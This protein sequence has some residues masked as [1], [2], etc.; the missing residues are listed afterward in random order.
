MGGAGDMGA[1][2]DA[3][4]PQPAGNPQIREKR[5]RGGINFAS[6]ELKILPN[7]P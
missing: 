4:V 3:K 6:N 2:E 5:V 1:S 7:K